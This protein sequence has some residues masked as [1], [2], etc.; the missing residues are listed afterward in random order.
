MANAQLAVQTATVALAKAQDD[1]TTLVAGANE[2]DLA[3]AQADVDK[4]QLA[5]S[6]A[7]TALAGTQLVASFDGTVL[8]TNANVG[9]QVDANTVVLTV[10]DLKGLQVVASVDET[11]IRRVSEGQSAKI[12][13]DAFPGQTFTG[14]VLSVPLQGTLAE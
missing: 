12:S 5:V 13:F 11:T 14:K 3:T 6:D 1:K 8:K 9:D 7:E 10:A 4:K 2:V